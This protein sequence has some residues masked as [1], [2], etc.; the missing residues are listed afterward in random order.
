MGGGGG[1]TLNPVV[2]RV[3]GE[4]EVH[5]TNNNHWLLLCVCVYLSYQTAHP[6]RA[7]RRADLFS[8]LV[9]ECGLT[10]SWTVPTGLVQYWTTPFICMPTCV[11]GQ[12]R[13]A[14]PGGVFNTRIQF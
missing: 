9:V 14:L 13:R 3:K 4:P 10:H 8:G 2:A 11:P 1:V 7:E 6:T 5:G 12:V